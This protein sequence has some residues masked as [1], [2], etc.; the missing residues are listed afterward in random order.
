MGRSK[1]LVI[2]GGLNI[3]PKEI[4]DVVDKLDGIDESALIG[5]PHKSVND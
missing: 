3:Y 4:E 2:S 5:V 1:D